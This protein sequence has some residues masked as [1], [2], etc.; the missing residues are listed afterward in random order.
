MKR[1][2]FFLMTLFY[3]AVSQAAASPLAIESAYLISPREDIQLQ[4]VASFTDTA[5]KPF[6]KD[7]RLGFI[8]KP[9]WIKLRISPSSSTSSEATTARGSDSAVVLR[10]GLLALDSIELYEQVDGE[11]VKQ[12]RGDMVK[13]KYASCQD[14]FHCFELRSDPKL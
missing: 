12:H 14:D 7:L 6:Q 1:L 10:A 11:W 2:W 13:Q 3:F 8:E 9:V 4:E 5:F